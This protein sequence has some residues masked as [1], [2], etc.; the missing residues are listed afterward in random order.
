MVTAIEQL[1]A[2]LKGKEKLEKAKKNII[3][4]LSEKGISIN[5]LELNMM[6]EEICNSFNTSKEVLKNG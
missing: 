5:E 2:D 4:L 3:E 1:Y 6:I